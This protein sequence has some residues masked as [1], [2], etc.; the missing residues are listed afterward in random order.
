MRRS[1]LQRKDRSELN[2]IA[3][4]LGA[5]P[6][7]RARKD[8]IIQLI[9]DLTSDEAR[10][11]AVADSGLPANG[12][13]PTNGRPS[14]GRPSDVGK[15]SDVHVKSGGDRP[16][17]V[18]ASA[19]SNAAADND[20]P[21]NSGLPATNDVPAN[22]GGPSGGDR[23]AGDS[24]KSGGNPAGT[25]AEQ[26]DRTGDNR[27]EPRIGDNG[28]DEVEPAN[29]RRR[30]RVRDRDRDQQDNWD[31]DS[32]RVTGRLDVRD[33]GYGFLR[34]EGCLPNRNDAY[35]PVKMIRQFG[36]RRGDQLSGT[37]RPANRTEKNP[38]LLTLESINDGP[39]EFSD[40]PLFDQLTP[41][42]AVRCLTLERFDNPDDL[43][44]RLIDLI[45][46][47]G[48]GQRVLIKSPPRSGASELL[49][50]ISSA[51]QSNDPDIYVIGLFLNQWPENITESRRV[52][53]NG[54]VVATSF[55]QSPEDHIQTA[56]MAVERAKR[57]VEAGRD[58]VVVL[59]SITALA[60]AY[61]ASLANAGRAFSGN[62]ESGA[63]HMPK[64]LF[65]AGRK[66]SEGGSLTM[67]ASITTSGPGPLQAALCE[68]FNGTAN[69]EIC[70]DRWA[71]Q[72][73]MFP[74]IDVSASISVDE[75][76]FLDDEEVLALRAFRHN[77]TEEAGEGPTAVVRALEAAL[78]KLKS[79]TANA[80]LLS[81]GAR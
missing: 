37:S 31:G 4:A 54:E 3:A 50:A 28:D 35:V 10:S 51:V 64:K 5:K 48:V 36:L 20:V 55:D 26:G 69:T 52:I 41:I 32:V 38:A 8:E 47:I 40:R 39:A 75:H 45:A 30:R 18:D 73:N 71:A 79:T 44:G 65:G 53:R 59:D 42:H 67:I 33:E 78:S 29:R 81:T 12:D 74:P 22:S 56:E 16:S 9:I 66:I 60:Q 7:S 11:G 27:E 58:V 24:R 68:E 46:P 72:L 34:V 70:L 6:P 21:A 43:S 13:G 25:G 23:A 14:D 80:E 49:A 76:R 61:N 17:D 2:Q 15:P 1:T 63:V 57:L 77:L 62:V 19:S